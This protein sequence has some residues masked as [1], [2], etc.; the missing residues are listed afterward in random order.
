M[1][2]SREH[3]DDRVRK[4]TERHSLA[5]HVLSSAKP[6]LPGGVTQDYGSLRARRILTGIEITPNRGGYSESA[7][8]TRADANTEGRLR[9][10]AR[11]QE[12]SGAISDF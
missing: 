6:L 12:K 3:S 2:G 10:F 7:K 5:D 8:E 9:T 11:I 1:K 4:S